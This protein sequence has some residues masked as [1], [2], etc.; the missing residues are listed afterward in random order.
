VRE[1]VRRMLRR[2][3]ERYAGAFA[4]PADAAAL[5]SLI[6]LVDACLDIL[7]DP[8]IPHMVKI[9]EYYRAMNII[10]FFCAN[11]AGRVEWRALIGLRRDL[12]RLLK[13][14]LRRWG[15]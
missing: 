6:E 5:R 11:C 4:E 8:T 7:E 9:M 13:E 3:E 2:V 15:A 10:D 12:A 1:V 14:G